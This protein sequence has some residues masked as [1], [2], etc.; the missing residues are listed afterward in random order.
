MTGTGIIL[1]EARIYRL[2]PTRILTSDRCDS[3]LKEL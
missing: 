2:N 1:I 3:N